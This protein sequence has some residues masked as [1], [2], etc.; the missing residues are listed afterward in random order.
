MASML[1]V[2]SSVSLV[3]LLAALAL[4]ASSVSSTSRQALELSK[5]QNKGFRVALKHVDS[6]KNLTKFERIQNGIRRGRYKLQKMNTMVLDKISDKSSDISGSIR[7]GEGIGEFYLN[8]A[9]GTPAKTY[10]AIVDT[11]SDLIW[12]QCEPCTKCYKQTAEIFDPRKSSTYSMLTC[13]SNLCEAL[14]QKTCSHN[15]GC[16]YYYTY[17]DRSSTEGIMAFETFTFGHVNVPNVGFGCGEDNEG[18]G[19][20]SGA[21][22][23]GLGRG[24]LSLVSQ[25]KEPIFSYCLPSYMDITTSSA[26]ENDATSG[27]LLMG[28]LASL[29]T[30]SGETKTTPMIKNPS[31]P[32]FYYLSL[33][34]ITVGGTYL[35][36]NESTALKEDGSDGLIIDSGTTVTFLEQS[37]FALVKEE[38]IKQIKLTVYNT[39]S[40]EFDVFDLCFKLPKGSYEAEVP[41]LIFHFADADLKFPV[42]NYMIVDKSK[43]VMCLAMIKTEGL[44]L[45]GNYQQQNMLVVH[46]LVKETVSFVPTK[47]AHM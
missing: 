11:G 19:F 40:S 42:E 18:G 7:A 29:N 43:G 36:V 6:G 17:G 13:S 24:P 4:I 46:D 5:L 16:Q 21:G 10:L 47:C 23:V 25:L 31:R 22:L 34:G 20:E 35:S 12:F 27:T 14:P 37:A 44:S 9:I 3:V 2:S 30:K 45:F 32:T 41:E 15:H 33:E 28:S 26:Y 38:F 39:G 8:L 1:H